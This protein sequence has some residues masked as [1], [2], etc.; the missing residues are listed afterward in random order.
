MVLHASAFCAASSCTR[1]FR[2]PTGRS[3][4]H[5]RDLAS[6]TWFP[7]PRTVLATSASPSAIQD[8]CLLRKT[9][10]LTILRVQNLTPGNTI[11]RYKQQ[12][13]LEK[14]KRLDHSNGKQQKRTRLCIYMPYCFL[15]AESRPSH[16]NQQKEP[17][18]PQTENRG[19]A[20]SQ[21][22]FPANRIPDI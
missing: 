4:G 9:M 11:Q 10:T 21:N 5:K 12:A 19:S 6:L 17:G 14:G 3:P 16:R 15:K 1:S 2:C 8:Y 20:Q 22:R 18:P 7:I 13:H